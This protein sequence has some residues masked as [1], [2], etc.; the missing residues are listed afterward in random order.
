MS[1]LTCPKCQEPLQPVLFANFEIDRCVSCQGLWFDLLEAQELKRV[2]GSEAIDSGDPKL[3]LQFNQT[4]AQIHCPKCQ[5]GMTKMVDLQQPHI[6][7]EKCPVCYGIW[8]DAGEFKDFKEATLLDY[9]KA[10][11]ARARP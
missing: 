11:F 3:G 4:P 1:Q 6:W 10:I 8:F 2:Q 7:Y 9:I 5:A